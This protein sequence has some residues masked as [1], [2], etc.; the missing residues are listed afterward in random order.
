MVRRTD[1]RHLRRII[2][3]RSLSMELDGSFQFYTWSILI[4][5]RWTKLALQTRSEKHGKR[6]SN[7]LLLQGSRT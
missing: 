7:I 1:F 5:L 4:I 6:S 2:L 3:G